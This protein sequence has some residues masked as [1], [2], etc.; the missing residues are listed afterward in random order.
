ML[1]GSQK[2]FSQ[3]A[4]DSNLI[5]RYLLDF[6][7]PDMPAFKA[8]G[9]DPSEILRPSD[10]KKFSA[11]IS[12]FYSGGKGVIPKNFALEFAPWKLASK[13]W[14]L[15]DFNGNFWKRFAYRSSFSLGTVNDSTEYSTKLGIGYRVS[16]LS[17]RADIYRA[18][19]IRNEIF[20]DSF[21][22]GAVQSSWQI[23]T[24]YWVNNIVTPAPVTVEEKIHYYEKHKK[25][26]KE[27]FLN[28][29]QY[30]KDHPNPALSLNYKNFIKTYNGTDPD[31]VFTPDELDD[32]VQTYGKKIDDFIEKYKKDNWNASRL[33]IAMA[34]VGQSKDSLL[35]KAQFSSFSLWLTGALRVHKGGQ[36]LI[37]F[38][39]SLPRSEKK[40]ST[41]F[42]FTF[43][44]RYYLGTQDFRGFLEAQYQYKKFDVN[45]KVLLLNLGAE[46]RLNNNFWIVVSGGIDNYL[47]VDNPFNKFVTSLDL[48]YGFNKARK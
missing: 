9:T 32:L 25:E 47:K 40:D 42:N 5:E 36:L 11:M 34:W 33:D 10:V 7:V 35:S 1:A 16:F 22:Q 12:P 14:T 4:P 28:I 46:F 2:C 31:H 48:R 17:K 38:K 43:N 8:L 19:E 13:G 39:S 29:D 23:L 15:S 18:A 26:F 24:D 37:G 3:N 45:E 20:S 30:L 27:F 6:S 44:L 21:G 41:K